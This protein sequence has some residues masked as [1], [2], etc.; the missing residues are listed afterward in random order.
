MNKDLLRAYRMYHESVVRLGI[1]SKRLKSSP[2]LAIPKR[3]ADV[4]YWEGEVEYWRDCVNCLEDF[5][6]REKG[7]I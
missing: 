2:P 1:A 6:G 5:C 7:L 3:Q 4:D